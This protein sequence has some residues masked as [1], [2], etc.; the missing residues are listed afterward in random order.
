MNTLENHIKIAKKLV[1][2]LELYN[3]LPLTKEEM[4]DAAES[5][6]QKFEVEKHRLTFEESCCNAREGTYFY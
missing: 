1:D 4:L 2:T 6:W 3:N 5:A